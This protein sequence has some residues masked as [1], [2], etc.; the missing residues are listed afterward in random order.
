MNCGA[1]VRFTPVEG[2]GALGGG[3]AQ[4]LHGADD[5]NLTMSGCGFSASPQ[6]CPD[7]FGPREHHSKI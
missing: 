3:I 5:G 4:P 2:R 7:R 1:T 6:H